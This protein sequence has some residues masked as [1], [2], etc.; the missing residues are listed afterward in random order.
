[1]KICNEHLRIQISRAYQGCPALLHANVLGP[2]KSV[3]AAPRHHGGYADPK[4]SKKSQK[5]D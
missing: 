4:N 1:M 5:L 2:N 3:D